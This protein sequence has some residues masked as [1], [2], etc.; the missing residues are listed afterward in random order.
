MLKH[1]PPISKKQHGDHKGRQ[2]AHVTLL[3][4]RPVRVME[5]VSTNTKTARRDSARQRETVLKMW[6]DDLAFEMHTKVE[7]RSEK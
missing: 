4:R 6:H 5:V 1:T 7:F 3:S 2:V